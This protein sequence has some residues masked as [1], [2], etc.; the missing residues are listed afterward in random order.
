MREVLGIDRCAALGAEDELAAEPA[1]CS[2]PSTA[3]A[4]SVSSSTR[5]RNATAGARSTALPPADPHAQAV[6]Q[7]CSR[8]TALAA[9]PRARRPRTLSAADTKVGHPAKIDSVMW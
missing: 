1:P 9:L 5:C 2:T 8:C 4:P 6:L 3:S 7:F